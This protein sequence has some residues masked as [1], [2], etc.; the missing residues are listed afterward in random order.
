MLRFGEEDAAGWSN[1]MGDQPKKSHCVPLSEIFSSSKNTS[2]KSLTEEEII[3]DHSDKPTTWEKLETLR[4]IEQWFPKKTT[5]DEDDDPD[6]VVLFQDISFALFKTSHEKL[7]FQLL[8]YFLS[9]LGVP[10]AN[11]AFSFESE[12]ILSLLLDDEEQLNSFVNAGH[13]ASSPCCFHGGISE[14]THKTPS[15]FYCRFVRNIFNQSLECFS[16]HF[17]A[18]LAIHWLNFEKN[19]LMSESNPKQRKQCYKAAR[20]LAK[21]LLKLEQHRNNLRLWFA[22]IEIEWI[23]GNLEEA[24]RVVSSLLEQLQ[25]DIDETSTMR[26]YHFVR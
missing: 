10:I 23:N 19:I 1:W 18:L 16:E 14:R 2:D 4:E 22:F 12:R 15:A 21:S 17:Q 9:F 20:K 11:Y 26:Y 6:R 13:N 24:R 3:S 7:K 5:D 25:N 8:C